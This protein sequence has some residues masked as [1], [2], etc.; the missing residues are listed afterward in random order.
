MAPERTT[1]GSLLSEGLLDELSLLVSP[2]VLGS[3]KRLFTEGDPVGLELVSAETFDNGVQSLELTA[4][5][6]TFNG[7][8]GGTARGANNLKSLLV[9][10]D[11]L[12]LNGKNVT[13]T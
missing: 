9:E 2:I 4:K 7:D 1:I 11:L 13:T 12:T 8:V 10:A 6:V 3:G 5:N